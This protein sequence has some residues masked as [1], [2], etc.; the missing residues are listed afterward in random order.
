[1]PAAMTSRLDFMFGGTPGSRVIS[2]TPMWVNVS[3][4]DIDSNNF[5]SI[6]TM[7]DAFKLRQLAREFALIADRLLCIA[8]TL[9]EPEADDTNAL[10]ATDPAAYPELS[11]EVDG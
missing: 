1:M 7:N 3:I 10:P 4:M 11:M 8:E 2:E 5:V 9:E 6:C